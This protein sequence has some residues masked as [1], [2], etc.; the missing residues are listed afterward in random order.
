[1]STDTKTNWN[2]ADIRG[3]RMCLAL[4]VIT[5]LFWGWKWY[6]AYNKAETFN[7]TIYRISTTGAVNGSQWR[8]AGLGGGDINNAVDYFTKDFESLPDGSIRF[9][10]LD[11][12]QVHCTNYK[13][14]RFEATFKKRLRD[15]QVFF[16]QP[17]EGRC[18]CWVRV[19]NPHLLD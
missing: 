17:R 7:S 6:D 18:G 13:A 2:E 12:S 16:K 5:A 8:F 14:S 1:M 3:F 11:G 15:N 10:T 19:V 4:V 9:T